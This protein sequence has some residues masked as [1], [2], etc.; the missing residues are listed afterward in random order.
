MSRP[1][2]RTALLLL[3]GI[4][5]AAGIGGLLAEPVTAPWQVTPTAGGPSVAPAPT[6]ATQP[7]TAPVL[8][9]GRCPVSPVEQ[10]PY[11]E[12]IAGEVV[13]VRTLG[14]RDPG[15]FEI[16]VMDV[17]D[18][19]ALQIS[20]ARLDGPGT[21]RLVSADVA[22]NDIRGAQP[23]GDGLRRT[24]SGFPPH[25]SVLVTLDGPGCWAYHVAGE[26]ID[27][28]LV[29][30]LDAARFHELTTLGPVGCPESRQR[31]GP[32]GPVSTAGLTSIGHIDSARTGLREI[33][34]FAGAPV[35]PPPRLS[36]RRL[37]APGRRM[38]FAWSYDETPRTRISLDAHRS[39]GV[40][41]F[42]H[43][44]GLLVEIPEAGCWAYTITGDGL[45]ERIVVAVPRR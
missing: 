13:E 43:H 21:M 35:Q 42:G 36:G 3:A 1:G 39:R 5:A 14:A 25:W 41:G 15:A 27:E 11:G 31:P 10:R 7:T 12:V 19:G 32:A 24:A 30:E 29:F 28:T 40:E 18:A 8:Q 38:R 20:G 44:W 37:D 17:T 6:A 26:D 45:T 34:V 23:L 2:T 4:A 16:F 9:D 22:N 33:L